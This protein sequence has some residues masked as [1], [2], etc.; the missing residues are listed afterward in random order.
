MPQADQLSLWDAAPLPDRLPAGTSLYVT[1]DHGMAT[2]DPERAMDADS[3][4]SPLRVGV[5]AARCGG[6]RGPEE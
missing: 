2:I 4:D 1:A 5:R 6:E 3:D